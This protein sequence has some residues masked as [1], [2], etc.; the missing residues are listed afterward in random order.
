[1]KRIF[2][3]IFGAG[4]KIRFGAEERRCRKAR[5]QGPARPGPTLVPNSRIALTQGCRWPGRSVEIA[6][7][8]VATY[9]L[10]STLPPRL[11][12]RTERLSMLCCAASIMVLID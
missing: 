9:T 5:P 10:M 1:M 11:P 3:R 2:K 8:A 4:P 7:S 6:E 12:A